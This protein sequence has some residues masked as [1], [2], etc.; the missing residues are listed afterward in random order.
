MELEEV[1]IEIILN[2]CKV[3]GTESERL[4]WKLIKRLYEDVVTNLEVVSIMKGSISCCLS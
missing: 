2:L 3:R 1:A 4:L